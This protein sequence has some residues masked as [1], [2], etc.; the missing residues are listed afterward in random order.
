LFFI[1]NSFVF[2]FKSCVMKNLY[3]LFLLTIVACSGPKVVYDYDTKKDF[4][5]YTTYNYYPDLK[6]GLSNF[7]DKR[8]ITSTDKVMT[9]KGFSKSDSPQLYINFLSEEYT[10]PS[11][12]SIG[13]GIGNGPIQ[14]G[15]GIPIGA[16]NQRIQLTVD[17]ID[18]ETKEL[19]WQAEADNTQNSRQT[20]ENRTGFFNVM[21]SKVLDKYPPKK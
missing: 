17:F 7:D 4:S 14:I 9:E 10:T 20:P 18:A 1:E 6:T 3:C 12:N 13:I 16:P 21:M 2:L 8:L 15:G 11:N 5:K 19:I